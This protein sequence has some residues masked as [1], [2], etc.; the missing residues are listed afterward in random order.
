VPEKLQYVR[1]LWRQRWVILLVIAITLG[2]A[3][4]VNSTQKPVYRSSMK[5][6]VGQG[7][8]LF[9]PGFSGAVEPFSQTM[10]NLL[11]SDVVARTVISNLSL[12]TTPESFLS[13]LHVSFRPQSSVLDASYDSSNRAVATRILGEVGTVFTRL[14]K[15]KLATPETQLQQ[16]QQKQQNGTAPVV[17]GPISATVFDPAHPDPG[18]VSPRPARTLVFSGLLGLMVGFVLAFVRDSLDDRIRGRRE[19]EEAFG[20][21]VIGAL[22][23]GIRGKPPATISAKPSSVVSQDAVQILR[24]NV[25]F[26]QMVEGPSLFVTS[27][28]SEEGKSTVVANLGIALAAAGK[29]VICVEADLRRPRLDYYLGIRGRRPG[30]VDVALG[31]LDLDEALYEVPIR[32]YASMR[33]SRNGVS[34]REAAAAST[35]RLRVLL[36]G[37]APKINSAEILTSDTVPRLVEELRA[38]ADYVLFDAPP[39]LLVGDAFPLASAADSVIVVAREGKTTREAAREVRA[40]LD[41]LGVGDPAIVLTDWSR[42]ETYGYAYYGPQRQNDSASK[43][44]DLGTSEKRTVSAE[45]KLTRS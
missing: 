5:I 36:A 22:P 14:V 4:F 42:R 39:L 13:R 1:L 2:A 12:D 28:V 20:A 15:E 23:R 33:Q 3:A 29:S 6:V 25:E 9:Q 40:T 7:G 30:L 43:P 26:S 18:V 38:R 16:Q 21:P 31:T 32:L 11:K 10:A 24:A 45:E 41:G 17:G 34:P 19:A 27:A 37:T 8:T 44:V 35:G